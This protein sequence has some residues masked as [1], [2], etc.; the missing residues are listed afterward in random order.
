M[1]IELK[2]VKIAK[3]ASHETLCFEASVYVNGKRAFVVENAGQGGC[4]FYHP[5]NEQGKALLKQAQDHAKTLP[6]IQYGELSLSMDLDCLIDDLL[7][8]HEQEQQLKRW[9]KTKTVIKLPDDKEGSY[10]SFNRKYDNT[11]KQYIQE[12]YPEAE[13]INEQFK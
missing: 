3:F 11:M 5:V 12:K 13:I 7:N 6:D 10:S 1:N 8:K 2:N 4:N 9:C